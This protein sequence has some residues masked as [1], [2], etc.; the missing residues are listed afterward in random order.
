MSLLSLRLSGGAAVISLENGVSNP[1]DLEFLQ[2]IGKALE[3]VR[4]NPEARGLVLTGGRRRLFSIGLN[5]PKLIACPHEDFLVFYRALN[6]LCLS[7]YSFPKPTVAAIS[8]HA[9]AGGCILAL[10]C[11]RRFIAEGRKLMG[12]NEVKLGLPVPYLPHLVLGRTVTAQAARQIVDSG[13]LFEPPALLSLG[14]VD[15]IIPPE[16]LLAE[17]SAHA[18]SLAVSPREFAQAKAARIEPILAE[19]RAMGAAKDDE[20]LAM[21]RSPQAQEKLKQAAEKF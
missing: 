20:F 2:E 5:L 8:G 18:L 16:A 9:V 10:C 1:L 11:D 15:R 21:W 13:E 17:A 6:E 14:L 4:L 7:L 19:Y 3:E 12:L